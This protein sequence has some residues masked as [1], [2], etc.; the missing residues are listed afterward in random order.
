MPVA[1]GAVLRN[2]RLTPTIVRRNKTSGG[3]TRR[4]KQAVFQRCSSGGRKAI[5]LTAWDGTQKEI[6]DRRYLFG[7]RHQRDS[8]LNSGTFAR[9]TR[10]LS[11]ST[12]LAQEAP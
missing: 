5:R 4:H 10:H 12:A 1:R 11:S 9:T 6:A 7:P 8:R 2:T 3:A